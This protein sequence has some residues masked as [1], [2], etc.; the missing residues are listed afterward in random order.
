MPLTT[1]TIQNLAKK[2]FESHS[3]ANL[4]QRFAFNRLIKQIICTSVPRRR[5]RRA[6]RPPDLDGDDGVTSQGGEVDGRGERVEEKNGRGRSAKGK[7]QRRREW[8]TTGNF[9]TYRNSQK[10]F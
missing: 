10:Y 8:A 3:N 4:K 7:Q 9:I 5:A 6:H 1:H 2:S